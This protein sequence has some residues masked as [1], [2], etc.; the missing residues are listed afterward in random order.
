MLRGAGQVVRERPD[1]PDA[2]L[3]LVQRRGGGHARLRARTRSRSR[4]RARRSARCSASTWSASP[5]RSRSTGADELPVH[6][7]RR[8][9]RGVR[10][11]AH[12]TSTS[13]SS[14]SPNAREHASRSAGANTRNS[15]EASW[16]VPG[17]PDAALGR[18]CAP[19]ATTPST[20]CPTTRWRRSTRS[21]AGGSFF[22]QGLRN[23]LLSA[24]Y[25]ALTL[26]NEQP[27]AR[28]T[29]QRRA[30]RSR[31][32]PAASSDPD[33]PVV[34]RHAGTSATARP[35]RARRSRTSTRSPAT[36]PRPSSVGDSLWPQ[37][38]STATVTVPVDAAARR[39][40]GGDAAGD[41]DGAGARAGHRGPRR[42]RRRRKDA[43]A[44]PS[45]CATGRRAVVRFT[46]VVKVCPKAKRRKV[47]PKK[48]S[49]ARSGPR[50]SA[51]A[52]A[53]L[54]S[55]YRATT[56]CGSSACGQPTPQKESRIRMT[57]Q[58]TT[59]PHP[60][61]EL[62]DAHRAMWAS[63]D[64]SVV[65][66]QIDADPPARVVAAA[67]IAAGDRVLDVATG[68]GNAALAAARAGAD[69]T[70]LDLT[71][72]L[73][74]VAARGPPPRASRSTSS[75]ATPRRCRSPTARS[76]ASPPC[77]ASSSRRATRSPRTSSS[78]CAR[79]GGTIALANWTPG[80][81]IG[82]VL[83]T[84]G[85]ATCRRRRRSRR[86]RR[87]GATRPTSAGCSPDTTSS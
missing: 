77:S 31:S 81:F 21:P 79:P 34:R 37:V 78:A 22:E 83:R 75:P 25:T 56:D 5:G 28:A 11:A 40:G 58:A 72:D 26:D 32:T 61:A 15:D 29:A 45:A 48:R 20:T 46:R 23:T 9:R 14:G 53:D 24:Y 85:L 70:G 80:R 12:A 33:G 17:L 10:R 42:R 49:A 59:Q 76:T 64:Y 19:P 41:R 71:P 66:Q 3:R 43:A 16:D 73:L 63:G 50:Q 30:A 8:R 74:E 69:V 54:P 35:A 39:R 55:G 7:A 68:T 84:V 36:T 13:T 67:G 27:V 1:Q 51:A 38:R 6:V 62:K 86:R 57:P 4:T 82:R 18:A 65:A 44:R 60:V 52:R 2:R 87:C 47:S